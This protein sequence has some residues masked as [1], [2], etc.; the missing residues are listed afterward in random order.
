MIPNLDAIQ[1]IEEVEKQQGSSAAK[2]SSLRE[3]L[4]SSLG[5]I[6]RLRAEKKALIETNMHLMQQNERWTRL[7]AELKNNKIRI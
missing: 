7:T 6:E 4:R 2:V 3:R 5:Q 1:L